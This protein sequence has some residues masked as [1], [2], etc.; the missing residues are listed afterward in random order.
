MFNALEFK[1]SYHTE[2]A[3]STLAQKA[4]HNKGKST[5][6]ENIPKN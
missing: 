3:Q 2:G 5:L 1:D 6:S 4:G